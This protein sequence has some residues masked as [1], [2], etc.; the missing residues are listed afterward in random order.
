MN[1]LIL[2][3]EIDIQTELSYIPLPES[4]VLLSQKSRFRKVEV[5]L[6]EVT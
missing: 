1:I 2:W 6:P 4:N 5:P 3:K